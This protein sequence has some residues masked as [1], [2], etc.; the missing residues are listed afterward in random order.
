MQQLRARKLHMN[1]KRE[2]KERAE[3]QV[4][5]QLEEQGTSFEDN[6]MHPF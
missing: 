3:K 2:E 5:W 1:W 4:M 6:C